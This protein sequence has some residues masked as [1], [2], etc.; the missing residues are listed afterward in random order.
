MSPLP[1]V[2]L[3]R[4]ESTLRA[5][6]V[7]QSMRILAGDQTRPSR[8]SSL[9]RDEQASPVDLARSRPRRQLPAAPVAHRPAARD[10]DRSSLHEVADPH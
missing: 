5:L 8:P 7:A 4:E 1:L 6:A 3:D 10:Q 9:Q 2:E